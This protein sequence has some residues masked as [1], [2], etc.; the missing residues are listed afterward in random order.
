MGGWVGGHPPLVGGADCAAND[1]GRPLDTWSQSLR[2]LH[3]T[4]H[5][6]RIPQFMA[7][8]AGYVYPPRVDVTITP[9]A[10]WREYRT[11]PA[12]VHPWG[13]SATM[14]LRSTTGP[15]SRAG[16]AGR[17]PPGWAPTRPGW[18]MGR[19]AGLVCT[20][21]ESSQSLLRSCQRKPTDRGI[22]TAA[23]PLHTR[24]MQPAHG[25]IDWTAL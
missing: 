1:G 17:R 5:V 6:R 9:C 18:R 23:D 11:P 24:V 22:C 25:G 8:A 19:R 15:C 20:P 10:A 4:V 21:A 12:L 7:Q 16:P 14:N 3:L 13:S 2:A